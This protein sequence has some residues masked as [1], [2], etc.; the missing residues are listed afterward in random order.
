MSR[1]TA[2][3]ARSP[4]AKEPAP[5]PRSRTIGGRSRYKRPRKRYVLAPERP[6]YALTSMEELNARP[7][8]G[9]TLVS[10]FSGC[11]GSCL[12]F[13]L[14]GFKPLYACEFID[15]ARTTYRANHPT[16]HVDGRDIREVTAEDIL[17][18]TGLKVGELDVLEGSPPCSSF[19][20]AGKRERKWGEV[21]A[22]SDKKQRTDDL[23]FEFL[24]LAEGLRPKVIVAENVKG[25]AV[26]KAKGVFLEVLEHLERIGYVASAQV[27]D[28][29]W[30]GV[31]QR[32]ER[33]IFVAVRKD[34]GL[35]PVFPK[36][37]PYRYS[38]K[39]T[40]GIGVE[41]PRAGNTYNRT[42]L[43][44]NLPAPCVSAGGMSM[45]APH[46]VN[47]VES[48]EF[49]PNAM[50]YNRGDRVDLDEPAPTILAL[51]SGGGTPGGQFTIAV[52]AKGKE[53]DLDEP[54]PTL[55]T[56]GNRLTHSEF[57]AVVGDGPSI[58]RFA[59]GREAAKLAPGEQSSKYM[60][61][62]RPLEQEPC[63]TIT[64]TGG[65][66]GA[67]SVIHPDG[68][69]K[70][71]IS[72]LKALCGFPEDFILTG[73]YRQQWERLGRAVPPPMMRAVAEVIRTHIF[74]IP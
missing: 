47:V 58:G 54:A 32:R 40:L 55:L 63:P 38:I 43:D 5:A 73:T 29:Q 34:L 44:P 9:L 26:G 17:T 53:H 50:S 57:V 64:Q 46:Q 33:L 6:P 1:N 45:F 74:G 28:A 37:L 72:E 42:D 69:R 41:F 4:D 19:S 35:E 15:E 68:T 71:T 10:T 25:L 67:A 61:L 52:R 22:Y 18:A 66:A 16:P 27:L 2:R 49:G 59:I 3:D 20:M 12:G 60:N 30:L 48:V 11:G 21:S 51:A 31:P 7:D 13:R 62:V 70:F 36:P 23:F 39:E 14:A 8:N 24:R 56:H 65:V